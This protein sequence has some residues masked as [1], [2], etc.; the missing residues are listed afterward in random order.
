[1]TQ[2]PIKIENTLAQPQ[3]SILSRN[4][5]TGF[6]SN[7][8]HEQYFY[9]SSSFANELEQQNNLQLNQIR[10][11]N[12]NR[13][14]QLKRTFQQ[15]F[16]ENPE[17]FTS[18]DREKVFI[19]V[20]MMGRIMQAFF[21]VRMSADVTNDVSVVLQAH[22]GPFRFYWESFFAPN[23]DDVYSTLNVFFDKTLAYTGGEQLPEVAKQ[24]IHIIKPLFAK[25]I[26]AR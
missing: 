4:M 12:D 8:G 9:N 10:Q 24:F 16:E 6:M 19:T 1:M 23:V 14:S 22:Y 21:P 17:I 15:R 18:I 2:A 7:F 11:Y 5:Q 26:L 20:E 13:L 25:H 3:A